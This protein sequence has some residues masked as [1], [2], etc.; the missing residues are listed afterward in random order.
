LEAGFVMIPNPRAA[1]RIG[2]VELSPDNVDCIVFWTKNP[3]PMLNKLSQIRAM[4]YEFYFQF[5]L[6]PYGKTIE[7]NLPPKIELIGAFAGLTQRLGIDRVMWRYDPI[8]LNDVHTIQWHCKCFQELCQELHPFTRRC[9]FSFIEPYKKIAGRFQEIQQKEKIA[10]AS[11]FSKIAK[12]YNLALFA[13]VEETDLMEYGIGRSSCIDQGLIEQI[14][15][16][17]IRAKKDTGQRPACTCIESVDIGVYDTCANG[18]TYCYA[19]TSPAT[20][21]RRFHKHISD[22]PM[23]AG[24]PTGGEIV[25]DRTSKS[26]KA[27]QLRLFAAVSKTTYS[28]F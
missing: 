20:A 15:G 3:I 9:V 7:R 25:T 26:H 23:L 17:G 11:E 18:C 6:T 14:F 21:L 27:N 10:I 28:L 19:T 16:C 2:R 13:C 22:S 1:N 4:R 8:L 24:Y 12:K 5:T